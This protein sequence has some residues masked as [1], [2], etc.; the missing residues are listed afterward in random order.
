[1]SMLVIDTGDPAIYLP[2]AILTV[3]VKI[4]MTQA[5]YDALTTLP[6]KMSDQIPDAD[7]ARAVKEFSTTRAWKDVSEQRDDKEN[8]WYSCVNLTTESSLKDLYLYADPT[9]NISIFTIYRLLV[10]GMMY[11]NTHAIYVYGVEVG[12]DSSTIAIVV[13][14][15]SVDADIYDPSI[16]RSICARQAYT[17]L[18]LDNGDLRKLF[19]FPYEAGEWYGHS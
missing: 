1:M 12:D 19:R 17:D 3:G 9:H 4:C 7:R 18:N 16:L 5:Q 8:F 6:V 11:P 14:D 13:S 10:C 15:M 2:S